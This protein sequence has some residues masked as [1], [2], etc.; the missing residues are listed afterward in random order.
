MP[1]SKSKFWLSL[2]DKEIE[3]GG[4][5]S[6]MGMRQDVAQVSACERLV[7]ALKTKGHAVHYDLYNGG[8]EIKPW[9]D[10]LLGALSWLLRKISVL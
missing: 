8:H 7:T 5:H 2:G 4:P 10:E 1:A 3:S 9:K 6:P